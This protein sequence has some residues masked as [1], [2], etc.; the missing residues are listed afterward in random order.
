MKDESVLQNK[1]FLSLFTTQFFGALNDN[2]LKNALVVLITYKGVKLW[3]LE[4]H[5]IVA[6]AGGV[7]ILPF[8]LFSGLAGQMSDKYEKAQM[9]RI[10]KWV[11]V[12]IMLVAAVGFFYHLFGLLMFSLFMMGLQ[13]TFFG[14]IKYSIIPELVKHRQL[15]AGNAFVE[16]GTFLAI[17]IGTVLGG[18]T[19]GIDN[20]EIY[21]VGTLIVVSVLGLI[22]SYGVPVLPR[23]DHHLKIQWNLLPQIWSLMKLTV[24]TKVVFNSILGISWFWFFGAALLSILPVLTKDVLRG[25]ENVVTLFLATFT[26]GIAVGAFLCEKLSFERV[27]IGLVPW[28]SLGMTIFMTDL[29]WVASIWS[30]THVAPEAVSAVHQINPSSGAGLHAADT[31][32]AQATTLLTVTQFL[33]QPMAYRLLL[34]LFVLSIFGGLFTV[35][36]YTLVQE[37]SEKKNRSRVIASNNILN[38]LFMVVS[39]VLLMGLYALNLTLSQILLFY[40]ALNLL[41]STYIYLVVPEFTLRF[42][43]WA[44]ARL[45]YRIRVKGLEHIPR[46]GPALLVCNHVSFVDWLI[47]AAAI[48]RPVRF[49]MYY[50]FFEIPIVKYLFRQAKVIPIA[51]V[52]ENK[53]IFD[54]AFERVSKELRDGELVCIFPEGGITRDGEVHKFKRGVEH[55]LKHD[56]VPV[57]PMA[58]D[59]LWGSIFSR[60][61]EHMLKRWPRRFWVLVDVIIAKPVHPKEATATK[62]ES[63]VRALLSSR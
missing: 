41:V 51:G 53:K 43:S 62:L 21:I 13:S 38:A 42:L 39:S 24:P 27:E 17:L 34:D 48:K 10:V 33:Q 18:V 7:F 4:P 57:L 55:I 23:A 2:V 52:Q 22:S 9:T 12:L 37:R 19:A 14:P 40:A 44:V 47:L 63:Q 15:T 45:M 8:F 29:S 60:K 50:K 59:G 61:T 35:P 3:G 11:E 6:L 36:L 20:A 58:L 46:E 30:I 32:G 26:V 28:G 31:L 16:I 49:V 56:A 54:Q 5:L 25:N 1:G